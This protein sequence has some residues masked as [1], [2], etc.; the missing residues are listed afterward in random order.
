MPKYN[1]HLLYINKYTFIFNMHIVLHE[2]RNHVCGKVLL[3]VRAFY[4]IN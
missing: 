1:R 3:C 4:S 2:S